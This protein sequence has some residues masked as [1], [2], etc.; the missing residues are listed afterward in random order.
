MSAEDEERFQLSN[1]CCICN[2]LFDIQ[3]DKVRDHCNLTEKC[4]SSAHWRCNISLKLTKKVPVIF[5][6][7]RGCNSHLVMQEIGEF[8]VK[9]SVI[10]LKKYTTFTINKNLVFIDS[11]H[12]INSSLDELIK[13][14]S[15]N[16]FKYSSKE[17]SGDLL[18]LVK[19]NGMYPYEYMDN[20]KKFSEDKLP[21]RYKLFSTL[22]DQCISEKDYLHAIDV[23][24][25]FR[26]NKMGD[27]HDL[28]LK[29]DI[30]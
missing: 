8:D 26:M 27:Y 7:L 4:R 14:L 16:D 17:F 20:L 30:L 28:Y 22:K 24:D 29:A 23:W 6:N 21:D 12:F 11:M 1:I 18:K 9:V 5:H 10:P 15:D 25:V 2:K 3:D 19:Q 13:N